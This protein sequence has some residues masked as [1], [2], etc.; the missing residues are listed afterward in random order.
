VTRTA[1]ITVSASPV[2]D[3]SGSPTSGTAPLTVSFTDLSSGSPTAWS[4]TFGDGG[5]SSAQHPSHDYTAAGTYTVSLTV[6]NACGSD[7]QTLVDYI[8]VTDPQ[9]STMMHVADIVVVK[10]NLGQGFKRG[11]A[12]V[13]IVDDN[14]APVAG[15]EVTGD[16]SGKT[17]ESGLVGTTDGSGN[18]V[19]LSQSEKGGGEW[20]FEV[21]NVTHGSLTYDP[22]ANAVTQSCESGDVF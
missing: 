2:A 5:S 14:G 19:F 16:F 9:P 21:T 3:F 12:T 17:N 15:A 6:S 1:Y 13:T 7:V 11:V 8:T 4:W 18:V 22:G 10:E 20:C